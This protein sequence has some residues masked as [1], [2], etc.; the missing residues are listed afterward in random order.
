MRW[1]HCKLRFLSDT[2]KDIYDI[3]KGNSSLHLLVAHKVFW[4]I[5]RFG[6]FGDQVYPWRFHRMFIPGNSIN[7]EGG[8]NEFKFKFYTNLDTFKSIKSA[9]LKDKNL[10]ELKE[11][12][13]LLS[14]EVCESPDSN[15]AIGSDRDKNWSY[16]I[17]TIWPYYINGV[18]IAW[19]NLVD[20][21]YNVSMEECFIESYE[22]MSFPEKVAL[23]K[24]VVKDIE[25]QFYYYSNHAFFHHATAV[26][27][28]APTRVLF[29][30]ESIELKK[31]GLF[32][33]GKYIKGNIQ[34]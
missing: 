30:K 3:A 22:N 20:Y 7:N 1:Y 13:I 5:L 4:P 14:K 21:F 9:I 25:K 26:F 23:Y 29:N 19:I 32:G 18:S 11:K 12:G 16:P 15:F 6:K 33:F 17:K 10:K 28:Y 8:F 24:G 31:T 34:F 2:E 27:G